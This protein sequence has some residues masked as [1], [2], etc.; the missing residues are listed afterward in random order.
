MKKHSKKIF[1][2]LA[3]ILALACALTACAP[4]AA[5]SGNAESKASEA[6]V[7]SKAE[8]KPVTLKYINYGAKPDKGNCD[9]I[10]KAMNDILL[11]DL[12]CTM[13]VEYLGSGDKAQMALKYAG[14]E[15]F[16]LSYMAS[17][18]GFDN[19]GHNNAFYELTMDALKQYAPYM[20]ENLPEIAWM[21]CSVGGKIYMLP[22]IN[23]GYPRACPIYRGDLLEKYGMSELQTMDDLEKYMELVANNEKDLEVIKTE[24]YLQLW[25]YNKQNFFDSIWTFNY[26]DATKSEYIYAPFEEAYLDYAKKMRSFYEKGIIDANSIND[27]T[28]QNDKFKNG[29]L[30]VTAHNLGTVDQLAQEINKEHPEWKVKIFNPYKGAPTYTGKFTGNGFVINRTS[31]HPTK[32][33]EVVN[34]IYESVELQKLLNFGVEGVDYEMKDGNLHRIDNVPEDKKATIGCNWN[35]GNQLVTES[36]EVPKYYEGVQDIRDDF[37]KNTVSHPLTAF[38]FDKTDVETEVA[39]MSAVEKE[40]KALD[41]GMIEDVEA[42]VTE[43]RQKLKAAGYDKVKAEYDRQVKEFMATYNN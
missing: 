26:A 19:L 39:N 21:Q 17:W 8:E 32:A 4:A 15:K 41:Y 5:S 22:R 30:A 6:P 43:Y 11:K 20:V 12:N 37:K 9:G 38:T 14:N 27:M 28:P 16:D 24:F 10:W 31:D 23:I 35:I 33:I 2:A 13:D 36:L 7:S 29:L 40:Y 1:A 42:A 25:L 18:W 3:L 34:H